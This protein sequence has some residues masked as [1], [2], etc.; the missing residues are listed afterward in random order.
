MATSIGS[1]ADANFLLFQFN[2]GSKH[3]DFVEFTCVEKIWPN[4]I[5]KSETKKEKDTALTTTVFRSNEV[6]RNLRVS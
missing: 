5:T 4:S 3:E 6:M 1:F 2:L